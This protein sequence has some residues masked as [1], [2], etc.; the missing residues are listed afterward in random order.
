MG[1][2]PRVSGAR[3]CGRTEPQAVEHGNIPKKGLSA[4]GCPCPFSVQGWG[5]PRDSD[6]MAEELLFQ[7]DIPVR[8]LFTSPQLLAAQCCCGWRAQLLHPTAQCSGGHHGIGRA[9]STAPH[10]APHRTTATD[11]DLIL[12]TLGHRTRGHRLAA[13]RCWQSPQ[14]LISFTGACG[15]GCSTCP[16]GDSC[17]RCPLGRKNIGSLS[18]RRRHEEATLVLSTRTRAEAV[19]PWQQRDG[20]LHDAGLFPASLPGP[21]EATVTCHI[22]W[23]RSMAGP[24]RNGIFQASPHIFW[25]DQPIFVLDGERPLRR[26]VEYKSLLSHC[27]KQTPTKSRSNYFLQ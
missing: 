15:W 21:A 25:K 19:A 11:G 2:L 16:A 13:S 18:C 3:T 22:S 12:P 5:T 6:G 17:S 4:Y 8:S 7:P 27:S 9:C 26:W 24:C 1:Q 23:G 14:P 20:A 10:L